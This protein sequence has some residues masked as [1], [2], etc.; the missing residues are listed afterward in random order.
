M[1][2]R[3]SSGNLL[4]VASYRTGMDTTTAVAEICGYLT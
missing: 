1:S 2:G 4:Y 3:Q